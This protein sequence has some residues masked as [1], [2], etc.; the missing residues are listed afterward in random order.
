MKRPALAA[1]LWAYVGWTAGSLAVWFF[2][3]PELVGPLAGL[4][5]M[6]ACVGLHPAFRR[7]A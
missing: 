3:A 7:A 5:A 6:G 1:A 4:A 2:G